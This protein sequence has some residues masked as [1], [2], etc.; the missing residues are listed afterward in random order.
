MN[1]NEHVE[2]ITCFLTD[3]GGKHELLLG[4]PWLNVHDPDIKWSVDSVNFNSK[5]CQKHCVPQHLFPVLVS[6][7]EPSSAL[8]KP[9]VKS[10]TANYQGRPRRVGAESFNALAQ[11]KE[12]QVFTAT[13]IDID[14]RIDEL[15]SGSTTTQGNNL[16]VAKFSTEDIEKAL[17]PK[18]YVDP[19]TKLPRHYQ[20][21]I[22][23]FDARAADLL[24]PHRSCDHQINLKPGTSPP[25]GPLYNMSVNELRVLRKWLDDNITKGF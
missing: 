22:D 6:G 20:Q 9:H 13:L 16:T 4:K 25:S 14:Q 7:T 2:I 24:P 5:F 19:L 17:R 12:V 23:T 1:I 18:E 15:T 3:L 21:H 8:A 11:Q 10:L